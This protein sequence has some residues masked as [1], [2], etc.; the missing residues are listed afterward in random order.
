MR[1]HRPAALATT[2]VLLAACNPFARKPVEI[3]SGEV[4][5]SSRWNATLAT[6]SNLTGALQVKGSAWMAPGTDQNSTIVHVDISNAAPGGVHPWFV[7]RGR[8]G[9]DQGVVGESSDYSP[10]RVRNDGTAS[11]QATLSVAEPASGDYFVSVH[12]SPSNLQTLIACGNLA[13]PV[14]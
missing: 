1:V 14:H 4:A 10:L 5:S 8:C 7:H 12:A 2:I 3:S 11:G 13:P 6:P 9:N